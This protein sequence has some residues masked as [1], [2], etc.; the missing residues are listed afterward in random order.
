MVLF[1]AIFTGTYTHKA[2][3]LPLG[4]EI[5]TRIFSEIRCFFSRG[6][7]TWWENDLLARG[8]IRLGGNSI[9]R[10][11]VSTVELSYLEPVSR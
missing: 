5:T 2:G 3:K 6:V 11:R 10:V 4:G 8:R 9:P 1:S 7:E